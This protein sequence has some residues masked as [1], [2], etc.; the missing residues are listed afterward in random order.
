MTLL[1]PD[2]VLS[3]AWQDSL[4]TLLLLQ[5]RAPGIIADKAN[6]IV[7]S[8]ANHAAPRVLHYMLKH[9]RIDQTVLDDGLLASVKTP[10]DGNIK[11]LLSKGANPKVND[12]AAFAFALTRAELGIAKRLLVA[13]ADAKM[14]NDVALTSAFIARDKQFTRDLLAQG[15][16]LETINLEPFHGKHF[17]E[18]IAP[19]DLFMDISGKPFPPEM[20]QVRL[21][22]ARRIA[23]GVSDS[24]D[25]DSVTAVMW[26]AD[27]IEAGEA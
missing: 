24:P 21:Q 27:A 17:L 18:D 19:K 23:Q 10:C 7:A 8:A 2:W 26:L 14:L 1:T 3:T 12:S 4:E 13:G 22:F 25:G 6:D 9:Y 16:A 5:E 20:R 15:A 11:I